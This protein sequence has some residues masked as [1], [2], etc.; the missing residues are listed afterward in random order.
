MP[1][2][3]HGAHYRSYTLLLVRRAL[4]PLRLTFC[5]V[6]KG[7]GHSAFARLVLLPQ[8]HVAR[9]QAEANETS[10]RRSGYGE[11]NAAYFVMFA[12]LCCLKVL[13]VATRTCHARD[14]QF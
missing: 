13:C 11:I 4:W 6:C 14:A 5:E 9:V 3:L 8:G 12:K 1:P 2:E 10:I 7:G